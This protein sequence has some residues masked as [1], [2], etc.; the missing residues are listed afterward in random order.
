MIVM[1]PKVIPS[2]IDSTSIVLSLYIQR[3]IVLSLTAPRD[4]KWLGL[5][6]SHRNTRPR[7]VPGPIPAAMQA[8]K[9]VLSSVTEVPSSC[10]GGLRH[11]WSPSGLSPKKSWPLL[12]S[13]PLGPPG[14]TERG[15]LSRGHLLSFVT[16]ESSSV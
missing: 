7:K 4:E 15:L 8:R 11:V 1:S 2:H 6:L 16:N 14:L 10:C 13:Y 3:P 9:R 5:V 12:H